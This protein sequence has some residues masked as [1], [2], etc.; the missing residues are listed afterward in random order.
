MLHLVLKK[1]WFDLIASGEKREEYRD[2][3]LRYR[4]MFRNFQRK[5]SEKNVDTQGKPRE[6][7]CSAVVA[8]ALGRTKATLFY[9]IRFTIAE[10]DYEAILPGGGEYWAAAVI[11]N[12][13]LHP[14]WGEPKGQH[15]VIVL[16][17]RVELED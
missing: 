1:K 3:T 10:G 8:F 9:A 14:E 11:R 15:Y 7:K 4:S 5:C 12:T 2:A 6:G 17:E 16:G 13:V